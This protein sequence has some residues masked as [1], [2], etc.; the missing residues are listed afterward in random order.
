[1]F[2]VTIRALR[3]LVVGVIASVSSIWLGCR[4]P[5][6]LVEHFPVLIDPKEDCPLWLYPTRPPEECPPVDCSCFIY[7]DPKSVLEV[8]VLDEHSLAEAELEPDLTGNRIVRGNIVIVSGSHTSTRKDIQDIADRYHAVVVGQ[9]PTRR[10]YVLRLPTADVRVVA[11][12][13]REINSD[14]RVRYACKDLPA[15]HE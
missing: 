8:K 1:M 9:M 3:V 5:A 14:S 6:H 12:I 15:S 2:Y 4:R 13:L 10:Y 7:P 11:R